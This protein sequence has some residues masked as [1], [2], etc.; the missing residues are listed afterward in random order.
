LKNLHELDLSYN[1]FNGS[2]PQCFNRLSSITLLDISSN[3]LT[4]ML[5]PSPIANLTS[6]EYVDFGNNLFEGS[7][8]F[9]SLSN[10]TMLEV[11]QFKSNN[12]QFQVE[13][14]EPIDWTPPF[15]LRIIVLSGCNLNKRTG[16][17]VP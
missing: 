5:M 1:M 16:S 7:F 13:T 17:F 4:G 9:S 12:S 8:S 15:Q 2:V 14:E 10:N 6:L 11:V 3:R